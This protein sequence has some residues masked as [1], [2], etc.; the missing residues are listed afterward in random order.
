M[1]DRTLDEMPKSICPSVKTNDVKKRPLRGGAMTDVV[2]KRFKDLANPVV[3]RSFN[4]ARNVLNALIHTYG[5]P[6]YISIELARDMSK[7]GSVR[8]DID[9]ENKARAKQKDQD[10]AAF[11]ASLGIA[12]PSAHAKSANAK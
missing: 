4:Q 6:A 10:Q 12:N 1:A 11:S 7:P 8:K 5:S 2:E 9:K 3:A